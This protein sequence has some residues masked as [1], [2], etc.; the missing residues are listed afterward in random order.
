MAEN[1]DLT[2]SSLLLLWLVP[3]AANKPCEARDVKG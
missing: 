3:E 2:H 1:M